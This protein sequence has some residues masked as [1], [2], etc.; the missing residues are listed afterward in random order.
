[1]ELP[2]QQKFKRQKNKDDRGNFLLVFP[3]IFVSFVVEKKTIIHIVGSK[4]CNLIIHMWNRGQLYGVPSE[5][6]DV[7]ATSALMGSRIQSL[8]HLLYKHLSLF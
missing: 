1:M 2:T 8:S 6:S 7:S 4:V 5:S 3:I